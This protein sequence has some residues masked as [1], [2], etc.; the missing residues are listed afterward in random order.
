MPEA[1]IGSAMPVDRPCP[2]PPA[3]G[4][5]SA[6]TLRILSGASSPIGQPPVD[7]PAEPLADDD[8]QLALY[9]S[10][11]MHYRGL[12]G[13]EDE[14][15]WHPAHLAWRSVL[16]SVVV[17]ALVGTIGRK[18]VAPDEVVGRLRGLDAA[19][20][21]PLARYIER[22]ATETQLREL[23]VHR[24]AYHL[25]EADPHTFAIPRLSGAAKAALAEIQA[26]EYG[27]GNPDRIHSTLF[28]NMM[29][30]LGLDATYG[31]YL[32]QIPGY[33]L[34]AVNV[35]TLFGLHR[36]WRGAAV[37]HLALF[38]LGSSQPNRRYGNGMRRLG[39]DAA[40]TAFHDEHVEADAV[41]S[42]IATYDLAARLAADDPSLASDI[43]FGAEVL[44]YVEDVVTRRL[45]GAWQGGR[46][47]LR[48]TPGVT[49]A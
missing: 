45:L 18:V 23:V 6:Q 12:Q 44:A 32:D 1:A 5:L 27:G 2:I 22:H 43:V 26:D 20:T 4:P 15:E 35:M 40:A 42:M 11:E 25:K 28:G 30:G 24:S 38:E 39:F 37:G 9:L 10:Y 19:S 17:D 34:A 31:A 48:G 16:E 13:I 7:V 47:S 49:A 21:M 8:L 36:R 3:R 41:H 33:S 46:S 14:R 29:Q